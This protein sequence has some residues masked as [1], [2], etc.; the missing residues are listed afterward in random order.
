MR[1]S[2]SVALPALMVASAA[3]AADTESGRRLAETR[4]V[5]CH[6]VGQRP[7]TS[8][9]PPFDAVARKFAQNPETLVFALRD[10]HPRMN[11][12]LSHNEMDDVA[13]YINSLMK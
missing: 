10:P 3:V 1:L 9:A 6:A 11:I 2:T 7:G 8:Q 5:P 13:A 12:T 4:C